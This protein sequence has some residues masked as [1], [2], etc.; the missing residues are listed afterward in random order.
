MLTLSY[1]LNRTQEN[2]YSRKIREEQ[3][4]KALVYLG[5]NSKITNMNKGFLFSLGRMVG[6]HPLFGLRGKIVLNSVKNIP[7]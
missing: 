3:V 1:Y 6:K 7:L 2:S 4:S 5:G